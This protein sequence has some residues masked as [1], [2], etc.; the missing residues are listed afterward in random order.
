[1]SLPLFH[2]PISATERLYLAAR[3]LA[4]P[5][6]IQLIVTGAG[7]IDPDRLRQA[8]GEASRACPGA[9][10]VRSGEE[11]VDSGRS[12]RVRVVEHRIDLAKLDDDPVLA[13][14]F[15]SDGDDP[16][17][18]VVLVQSVDCTSVVVRAFHGVMDAKGLNLWVTDM[19]RALRDEPP[20]GAPDTDADQDLVRR[21]KPESAPTALRP[22]RRGPL[23]RTGSTGAG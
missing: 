20:V 3:E 13:A 5:F 10:L 11:W 22:T 23:G 2:R 19:F 15:A 16:T 21:N 12:P 14:P 8:V 17:T 7:R 9:R 18:E 6:A 4:P 1:M